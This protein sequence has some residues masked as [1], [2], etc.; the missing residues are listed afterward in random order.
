MFIVHFNDLIQSWAYSI[1]NVRNHW[2]KKLMMKLNKTHARIHIAFTLTLSIAINRWMDG[3]LSPFDLIF[4]SS[5]QIIKTSNDCVVVFVVASSSYFLEYSHS[6][7]TKPFSFF[8][9]GFFSLSLSFSAYNRSRESDIFDF[10]ESCNNMCAQ[11]A[12][13]MHRRTCVWFLYFFFTHPLTC[14][15]QNKILQLLQF[16]SY[17]LVIEII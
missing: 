13:C 6:Y 1:Y 3:K 16:Y 10:N 17:H 15:E 2:N 5:S 14:V 7:Y 12:L 8:S 11:V 9:S 4:F